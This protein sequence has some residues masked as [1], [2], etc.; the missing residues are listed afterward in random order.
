[1]RPNLALVGHAL[2]IAPL[3]LVHRFPDRVGA[4]VQIEGVAQT[5][6]L[7]ILDGLIDPAELADLC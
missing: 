7:S 1:M 6:A 5:D 4:H 2:W 3:G